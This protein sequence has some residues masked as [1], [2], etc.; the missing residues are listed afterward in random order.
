[1]AL[2]PMGNRPRNC[3][4][5]GESPLAKAVLI[6]GSRW[7][8]NLRACFFIC[9]YMRAIVNPAVLGVPVSEGGRV[10]GRA[11]KTMGMFLVG[12]CGDVALAIDELAVNGSSP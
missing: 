11:K 7:L 12:Y 4:A 8:G 5:T 10:R 3:S 9:S 2:G 1:M 6:C